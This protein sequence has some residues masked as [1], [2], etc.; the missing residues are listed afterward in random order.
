MPLVQVMHDHLGALS[1]AIPVGVICGM[2]VSTAVGV[3]SVVASLLGAF[4]S[5]CF[6]YVSLM[7]NIVKEFSGH[8]QLWRKLFVVLSSMTVMGAVSTVSEIF[9]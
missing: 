7:G 2:L 3:Q 5:G 9:L 8:K 6:V 4:A 1:L